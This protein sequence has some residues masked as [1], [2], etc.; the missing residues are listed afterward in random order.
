MQGMFPIP[1][2]RIV[3]ALLGSSSILLKVYKRFFLNWKDNIHKRKVMIN[4]SFENFDVIS[5]DMK[6]NIISELAGTLPFAEALKYYLAF[7]L[8]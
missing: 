4:L 1:S 2:Q 8:E 5:L 6:H 3:R 7:L